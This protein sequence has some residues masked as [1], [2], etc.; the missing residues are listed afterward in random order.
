MVRSSTRT[1]RPGHHCREPRL[2]AALVRVCPGNRLQE[3]LLLLLPPCFRSCNEGHSWRRATLCS[4]ALLDCVGNMGR[5]TCPFCSSPPE[6]GGYVE[7][8]TFSR[9]HG[10]GIEPLIVWPAAAVLHNSPPF[11][12]SQSGAGGF[13]FLVRRG[14]VRNSGA[15]HG[16]RGEVV[17]L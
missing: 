17:V 11:G 8:V 4:R 12:H 13:F 1:T 15:R 6:A 9:D 2:I 14:S 3:E 7:T 5:P 16:C 10:K